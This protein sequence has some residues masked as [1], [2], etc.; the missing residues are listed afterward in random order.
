MKHLKLFENFEDTYNDI[1]VDFKDNPNRFN[2]NIDNENVI[3]IEVYYSKMK[4]DTR[5]RKLKGYFDNTNVKIYN[6]NI[7]PIYDR[8][9]K[10]EDTLDLIDRIEDVVLK[11]ANFTE[12]K[13]GF[14]TLI[15]KYI[16]IYLG[17]RILDIDN[18]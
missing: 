1:L 16:I 12:H 8:L 15:G 10:S 14:F 9:K 5:N 13:V 7:G 2:V 11:L 17:Q 18:M 4:A 6:N 3:S